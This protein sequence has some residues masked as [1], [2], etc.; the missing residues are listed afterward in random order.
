MWMCD[1]VTNFF[2][3]EIV[4]QIHTSKTRKW[5]AKNKKPN[6]LYIKKNHYFNSSLK[7]WGLTLPDQTGTVAEVKY[8][9][10]ATKPYINSSSWPN[11]RLWILGGVR[12]KQSSINIKTIQKL[13]L[14]I[15]NKN[16]LFVQVSKKCV[17][18]H[19]QI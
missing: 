2:C 16:S 19:S 12:T 5:K 3:V 7:Y 9:E 11:I 17:R 6:I 8:I 18:H 10:T 4:F 15:K 13:N 14:E 1:T